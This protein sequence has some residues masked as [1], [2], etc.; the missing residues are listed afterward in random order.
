MFP[1]GWVG[2]L[3]SRGRRFTREQAVEECGDRRG[4]ASYFV[5][6]IMTSYVFGVSVFQGARGMAG[7]F[8]FQ[9]VY[10]RESIRWLVVG[11]GC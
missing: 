10:G 6:L 5:M 7:I 2:V 4:R 1:S 8:K 3:L 9:W 11:K